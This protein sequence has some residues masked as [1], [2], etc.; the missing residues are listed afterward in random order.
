MEN[1]QN[2]QKVDLRIQKNNKML[3]DALCRLLE[4][5]SFDDITVVEI[6]KEAMI[7]RSAF[8][9][10]FQ[11]KYELFSYGVNCMLEEM[12]EKNDI[13]LHFSLKDA[14]LSMIKLYLSFLEKNNINYKL[15]RTNNNENILNTICRSCY[16]N[17]SAKY[18]EALKLPVPYKIYIE[19]ISAGTIA[20][21]DSFLLGKLNCSKEELLDYIEKLI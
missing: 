18:V 8:Y 4:K 5:K 12:I 15:I 17:Y 13:T 1:I 6:C 3:I 21:C 19:F 20:L 10:R 7:S 16:E 14:M 2:T 11:D 9:D